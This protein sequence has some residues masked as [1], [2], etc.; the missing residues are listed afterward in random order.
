[1]SHLAEH[2]FE[3]QTISRFFGGIDA[4][5]NNPHDCNWIITNIVNDNNPYPGSSGTVIS[6]MSR[7]LGGWARRGFR[8]DQRQRLAAFI[9]NSNRLKGVITTGNSPGTSDFNGLLAGDEQLEFLRNF[10]MIFAY[11]NHADIWASWCASYNGMRNILV[12]F[13]AAYGGANPVPADLAQKWATFNRQELNNIA[14]IGREY[15]DLLYSIK[16][17]VG[18][19]WGYWWDLKWYTVMTAPIVNQRSYIKFTQTCANLPP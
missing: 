6:M 7:E 13:D 17:P 15:V 8:W 10:G 19:L 1:M 11:W 12:Q 14:R 5:N 9:T 4:D 3:A 18:G 2:P 16:K